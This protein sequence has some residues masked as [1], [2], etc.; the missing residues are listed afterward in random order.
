MSNY[1][2]DPALDRDYQNALARR[3]ELL[4]Q[5]PVLRDPYGTQTRELYQK[6]TDRK[7]FSYDPEKDPLY[8]QYRSRQLRQ[9]QLAMQDAMG[10]AAVRTGGYA[11]SY[12]QAVG[13]QTYGEYLHKLGQALPE[14]YSLAREHYDADTEELYRRYSASLA[15]SQ[16]NYQRYRDAMS[17]Y[18]RQ[19]EAAQKQAD[20]AY[21]RGFNQ[22][23]TALKLEQEAQKQTQSQRNIAYNRLL[24]LVLAGYTPTDQEL[25][26]AG[27]TREQ[28]QALWAFDTAEERLEEQIAAGAVAAAVAGTV[29]PKEEDRQYNRY[30]DLFRALWPFDF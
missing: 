6:I 26:W 3:A 23:V 18:N 15:Q 25:A 20:A 10:Q 21:D 12:G 14:F 16:E 11:S 7:A 4:T 30:R 19:L 24:D 22:W 13:Q 17:D 2:Y 27:M 8:T 28:A 5:K 29:R 9:G 1:S